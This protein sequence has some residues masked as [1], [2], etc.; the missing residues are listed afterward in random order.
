ML[1]SNLKPY[2][3][4]KI[5]IKLNTWEIIK[6]NVIVTIHHKWD[7]WNASM[8]QHNNDQWNTLH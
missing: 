5:P 7:S 2:D 8:D 1:D 4:T 6:V 3:E